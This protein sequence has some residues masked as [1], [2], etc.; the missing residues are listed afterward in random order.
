MKTLVNYFT[1]GQ[2]A[3]RLN[4]SPRTVAEMCDS[5]KLLCVRIPPPVGPRRI[6]R[7]DL[8]EFCKQIG[9]QR[10]VQ[11]LK[12]ETDTIISYG[13]SE[14]WNKQLQAAIGDCWKLKVPCDE[15]DLGWYCARSC[16]DTIILLA[17]QMGIWILARME[18]YDLSPLVIGLLP[19]D[20]VETEPLRE[21]FP[22]LYKMP[23]DPVA[24]ANTI[25]LRRNGCVSM[26]IK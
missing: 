9:M 23:V 16:L 18:Q 12:D 3:R 1:T 13:L 11:Y 26:N 5:G 20:Q 6:H 19:E 25:L 22:C 15:L 7:Q 14:S 10:E 24:V 4:V 8:L 17:N 21:A 2:V